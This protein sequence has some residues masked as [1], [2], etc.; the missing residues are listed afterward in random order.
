VDSTSK[1][2]VTPV[3]YKA[4][5]MPVSSTQTGKKL[6]KTSSD[7]INMMNDDDGASDKQQLLGKRRDDAN[8]INEQIKNRNLWTAKL[9][10]FSTAMSTV[11]ECALY[12]TALSRTV[13]EEWYPRTLLSFNNHSMS[14]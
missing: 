6:S 1:R 10:F 14:V 7:D 2:E 9:L 8:S 12:C 4:G 5:R 11:G 13:S 3:G